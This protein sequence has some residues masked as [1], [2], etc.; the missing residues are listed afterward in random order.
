[1]TKTINEI[2]KKNNHKNPSDDHA[3]KY[4][5]FFDSFQQIY[6]GDERNTWKHGNIHEIYKC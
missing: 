1:M 6:S 5:C 3:L 2:L 4:I